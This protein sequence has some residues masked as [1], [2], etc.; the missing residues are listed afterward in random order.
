MKIIP[1]KMTFQ[2]PARSK[3]GD[4]IFF[5]LGP[6]SHGCLLEVICSSKD[7]RTAWA[8]FWCFGACVPAFGY[9]NSVPNSSFAHAAD[10]H[11]QENGLVLVAIFP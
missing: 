3:A 10:F 9:L 6:I 7:I 11:H 8:Q 2:S 1:L 5:G 4:W